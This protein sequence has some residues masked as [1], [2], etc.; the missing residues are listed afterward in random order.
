MRGSSVQEM[1]TNQTET[2]YSEDSWELTS[3]H[4][5]P[6]VW[7]ISV[8]LKSKEKG[9]SGPGNGDNQ[10]HRYSYIP[11]S[12]SQYTGDHPEIS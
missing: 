7:F 2:I 1:I 6:P 9:E 4:V 11:N 10:G 3:F 8:N 5:I 12:L